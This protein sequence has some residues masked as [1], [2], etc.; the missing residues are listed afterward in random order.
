MRPSR[1][2]LAL[3]A[4]CAGVALAG[5]DPRGWS[6]GTPAAGAPM[7]LGTAEEVR[8]VDLPAVVTSR[9]KRPTLLYYVSPTCP[10]CMRVAPELARVAEAVAE[11]ADVI[12]VMAGGAEQEDIDAFVEAYGWTFPV[13]HDTT[14]EIG[15]AMGARGTPSVLLVERRGRTTQA[16][17]AWYPYVAGTEPL[18]VLRLSKDPW[19]VVKG[20]DHVGVRTCG[21]CHVQEAASWALTHHAVAWHT[22]ERLEKT[23]DASCVPCHVTGHGTRDGWSPERPELRDVGCEACHGPS[24]PHDG[25]PTVPASTCE[26]C[27]DAEHAIGFRY[28]KGLPLLDHYRAVHMSPEG[29]AEA[30]QALIK[31]ETPQALLSFDQGAYVG[32]AACTGCHAAEHASWQASPHAGA[33]ERL[34][35]QGAAE[36]ARCVG[37][38]AVARQPGPR[39]TEIEAFRTTEG[40]GCEGCHGPGAAHVAAGGGTDTIVGLGASCP[41]CVI[42]AVCTSCHTSVWDPTWDLQRSLERVRHGAPVDAPGLTPP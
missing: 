21:A 16:L 18:V 25:V 1:R 13:L 39:P 5:G 28:D 23:D 14:R 38:H 19:S 35:A 40:V 34:A 17:Q 32:S 11:R 31:G 27:H 3:F 15:A 42:E 9:L 41:V 29:L 33:M 8:P 26:G 24:G 6:E 4:L 12:G 36:D 2:V 37:C 22:L 10:H 30:R 20:G 7:V